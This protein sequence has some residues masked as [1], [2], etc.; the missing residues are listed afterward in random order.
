[1][2][3]PVPTALTHEL[4]HLRG[5]LPRMAA[6]WLLV[7]AVGAIAV[8]VGMAMHSDLPKIVGIGILFAWTPGGGLAFGYMGIQK[9]R[10]AALLEAFAADRSGLVRVRLTAGFL[11]VEHRDGR[12]LSLDCAGMAVRDAEEIAAYLK[13]L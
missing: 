5:W 10:Q 3:A 8:A 11:V 1:M 6:L 2:T 9:R 4:A 7:S 12:T 13:G